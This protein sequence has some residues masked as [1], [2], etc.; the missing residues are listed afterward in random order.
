MAGSR[1]VA[2]RERRA[3]ASDGVASEVIVVEPAEALQRIREVHHDLR[4]PL[5]A[6][7]ALAA[8]AAAQDDVPE[9]VLSCL[10]RIAHETDELLQMCRH[11]LDGLCADHWVSVDALAREVTE[12][13]A[14]TTNCAIRLETSPSTIWTD[15]VELRRVLH[16]VI[17]NAIRAAGS[18]GEV[19]VRVQPHGGDRLRIDVEDSGPGFGAGPTGAAGL[20]TTV[21]ERY[22]EQH[23]GRVEIG[24]SSLGGAAIGLVLPHSIGIT[25]G[26]RDWTCRLGS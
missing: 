10:A 1:T 8:A 16:N 20:G 6:I 22:A 4:Q 17:E 19:I 11:V 21:V 7:G 3:R 25:D 9:Q 24:S 2:E 15:R 18:T 5:A 26:R 23:D 12:S 13:V 14:R